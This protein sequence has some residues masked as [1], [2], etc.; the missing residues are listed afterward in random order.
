MP[1]RWTLSWSVRA[2]KQAAIVLVA[3][4]IVDGIVWLTR[5]GD[6]RG[7][8]DEG[9]D[10]TQAVNLLVHWPGLMT[11]QLMRLSG[12]GCFA[13]VEVVTFVQTFIVAWTVIAIWR[14]VYERWDG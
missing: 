6:L 5:F 11:A 12:P 2:V 8:D 14:G 1:E 13:V 3:F 4:I 9:P 10:A 7:I